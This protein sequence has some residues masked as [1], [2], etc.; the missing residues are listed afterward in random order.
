MPDHAVQQPDAIRCADHLAD[1]CRV[2]V[3]RRQVSPVC[4]SAQ[5]WVAAVPGPL[6]APADSITCSLTASVTFDTSTGGT[7]ASYS[8]LNAA[9]ISRVV[10]IQR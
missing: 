4:L 6:P 2:G 8:A 1:V 3:E 5:V 7:S 9:A 10:G